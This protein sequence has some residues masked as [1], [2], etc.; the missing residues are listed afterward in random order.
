MAE[1]AEAAATTE[2][3]A[4]AAPEPAKAFDPEAFKKTLHLC[5]IRVAGRACS[6]VLQHVRGL[7]IDLPLFKNIVPAPSDPSARVLLLDPKI[8]GR[9]GMPEGVAEKV[10]SAGGAFTYHD[11][12][13]GIEQVPMDQIL[14]SLLPQGLRDLPSAFETIGHI[15]HLNLREDLMPYASTIGQVL[16]A[17]N[18]KIRTVVTKVGN[19]E[20]QF[21]TFP[22]RVIAGEDN[23][24]AEVREGECLFRFNFA[25]VYWNSRLGTEHGR[26]VAQFAPGDAVWDVFAG[27]GPFAL[28]A[29]K[30]GGCAV[31]AND[32][33]PRSYESLC[34]NAALNKL[35]AA[36]RCYNLDGRD[37]LRLAARQH[38]A[39]AASKPSE[40]SGTAAKPA[41]R[42]H[43]VMNLPADAAEFLDVVGELVRERVWPDNALVHCYAFSRSQD[44]AGDIRGRAVAAAGAGCE[45]SVAGCYDVRNVAPGKEMYCVT[46]VAR[47]AA[48]GVSERPPAEGEPPAKCARLEETAQD[49]P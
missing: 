45:L 25:E 32:L 44:P 26:L 40:P 30:V 15:A 22:M 16:L 9:E 49:K 21:R 29:A 33:N 14:R 23:L 17:K 2:A 3:A 41:S 42:I 28:P 1:T 27:V 10:E 39:A 36:V 34:A 4:A 37:F 47:P 31:L 19:I 48:A 35:S 24:V 5:A 8:Q 12:V 7:L 43:V 13:V 11:V 46:F 18:H 38:H 20:T 6:G